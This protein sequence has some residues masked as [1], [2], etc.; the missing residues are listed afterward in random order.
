MTKF[1]Q[2]SSDLT[3]RS[4]SWEYASIWTVDDAQMRVHVRANAYEDQSHATL[5]MWSDQA[6]WVFYTSLPTEDW[7]ADAPSYTR[8]RDRITSDDLDCFSDVEITL[9]NRFA[10]ATFGAGTGYTMDELPEGVLVA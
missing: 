1:T 6:G 8:K 5:H 7:Y 2:I 10:T 9:L 3:H 4:Q